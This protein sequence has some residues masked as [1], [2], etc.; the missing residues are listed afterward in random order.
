MRRSFLRKTATLVAVVSLLALGT[1]VF[2]ALAF[3]GSDRAATYTV[4]V[5]EQS[6]PPAGTPKGATLN[7]FFPNRLQVTAGDK[8]TFNSFGFHTVTHLAGGKPQPVFAPDPANGVYEA[9]VDDAGEPFYF[10]GKPKF[11]YNVPGLA[12]SGPPRISKG[13]PANSGPLTSETKKPATFTFTFPKPGVYTLVCAIHRGM[14]LQVVVK[15]KGAKVPSAEDVAALA[16]AQTEA[17]WQKAKALHAA[18]PAANTVY[19]GI[20]GDTSLLDFLPDVTRVKVGTT[21]TF[22]NRA[23]SE[24]HNVAFGP[25]KYMEKF[26]KE[27][28]FFPESPTS[29]NQVTPVLLYGTDAPGTYVHDHANHGNGFLVTPLADGVAGGLPNTSKITF[30]KAGRY[31]FICFLHGPDMSADIVV[32][33]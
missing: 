21:V 29:E 19:M 10:G 6:R 9:I 30:T 3:G 32:T 5:G 17:A 8:V 26:S 20:G 31:R 25:I 7:R 14:K 24:V 27:T 16:K 4:L 15:A 23:P 13:T 18:K 1:L 11:V 12:P 28:D 2:G 22:V 33:K